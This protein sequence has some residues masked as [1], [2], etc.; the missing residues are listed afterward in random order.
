M[1]YPWIELRIDEV[2][3]PADEIAT[4]RLQIQILRDR[5]AA[6]ESG[7]FG[8]TVGAVLASERARLATL[9]AKLADV[10]RR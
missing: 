9:E 10:S 6:M 4:L 1:S 3:M 7:L 8:G 5:I 2:N